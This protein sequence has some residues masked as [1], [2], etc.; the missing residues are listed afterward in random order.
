MCEKLK[1]YSKKMMSFL[2]KNA[3][4]CLVIVFLVLS[5]LP[6]MA[7]QNYCWKL[8]IDE[9]I[10]DAYGSFLG[11]ILSFF[12]TF[13]LITT[14]KEQR[15]SSEEQRKASEE[16]RIDSIFWGLLQHLQKETE[17]L[18]T[19]E[20]KTAKGCKNPNKDFFVF[21]RCTLQGQFLPVQKFQ[22]SSVQKFQ[23]SSVQK[24]QKSSAQKFQKNNVQKFQKSSAQKFQKSSAQKF[25]K[26]FAQKFQKNNV[27]IY[28]SKICKA[29]EVYLDLYIENPRLASYF[30]LLYRICDFIDNAELK[31]EK[32]KDYLK[33]LRAQLTT[34]ELF[35]L[36]YN[37][38]IYEGENFKRYIN[39]YNL[40]KHLPVFELLEFKSSW[41][42]IGQDE[43]RRYEVSAFFD[44]CRRVIN[45]LLTNP[46][47]EEENRIEFQGR[48][49]TIECIDSGLKIEMKVDENSSTTSTTTIDVDLLKQLL[50]YLLYEVFCYSNFQQLYSPDKLNIG[51]DEEGTCYVKTK[52]GSCLKIGYRANTSI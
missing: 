4:Y 21:L 23:K 32:K 37:A 16:A 35:L 9:D 44:K 7:H 45:S 26:G 12:S 6:F 27:Q 2:C 47:N 38:Q 43:G 22:K 29:R 1:L 40:L 13:I 31:E 41:F 11:G 28:Q 30:R 49:V 51:I 36:R 46:N 15:K 20:Y 24:F 8:P 42:F 25:Q 10:F 18:N 50:L 3:Y 33:F 39:K 34:S 5:S 14:L 17:D 48:S 19:I 52:D